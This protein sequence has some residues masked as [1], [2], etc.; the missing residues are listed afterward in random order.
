M[1]MPVE[2]VVTIGVIMDGFFLANKLE[3]GVQS[4]FDCS[5]NQ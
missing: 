1:D 4:L 3:S 5:K 2:Q